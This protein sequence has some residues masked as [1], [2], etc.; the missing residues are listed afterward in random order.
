MFC[1][2]FQIGPDGKGKVVFPR[3]W[4]YVPP[5]PLVPGHDSAKD[6][7]VHLLHDLNGT[8][9]VCSGRMD[10]SMASA[11]EATVLG[12]HTD[13]I[14]VNCTLTTA[15]SSGMSH[16]VQGLL[17]D[18]FGRGKIV[19]VSVVPKTGNPVPDRLLH[20]PTDAITEMPVQVTFDGC[21]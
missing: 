17:I 16:T 4:V 21:G 9:D 15:A 8:L 20:L 11:F 5:I 7:Q 1:G 13:D 19:A 12:H 18:D 6:L 14:S 10:Y 3:K 2:T